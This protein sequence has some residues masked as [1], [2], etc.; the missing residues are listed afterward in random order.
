MRSNATQTRR[1]MR[2]RV[3]SD[4]HTE[5]VPFS[6]P[7][8]DEP[9]DAVVLA[10]DIG[11]GVHAIQWAR[12]AFRDDAAKIFVAGNHEYYGGGI[13]RTAVHMKWAAEGTNI[14]FLDSSA[15]VLN[16]TRF[17]GTTLWSDFALFGENE[18]RDYAMAMAGNCMNDFALIT[19]GSTG[20]LTP[21]QSVQLHQVAVQWL[22]SELAKPFDGTTV[23]VTHHAPH[24]RS[25]SEGYKRDALTPAFVSDLSRMMGPR[26]QLW[27]HGHTHDCFDYKVNGTRVI[28]NARGYRAERTG[29]DPRLV[30]EV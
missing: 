16:G 23:V 7:A 5:L 26:V 20:W 18:N 15:V 19:H 10:G 30:V 3:M 12:S 9:V 29:F 24:W 4:L 27:I 17:L 6:P 11:K 8:L 14:H 28:C 25:V 22:M 21:Q 2:I 13:P 1:P